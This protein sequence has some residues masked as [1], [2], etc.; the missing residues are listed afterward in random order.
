MQFLAAG[1]NELIVIEVRDN[2]VGIPAALLPR[3]FDLFRQ[4]EEVPKG[5]FS[6]LGIGLALVKSLVELHGGNVSAHSDGVGAGSAFVVRLPRTS[7]PVHEGPAHRAG[8]G[9]L[10]SVTRRL[11]T[12]PMCDA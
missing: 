4:G 6:G 12:G 11:V 2:G 5:V 7:V 8:V 9:G 3:M 10:V 1:T